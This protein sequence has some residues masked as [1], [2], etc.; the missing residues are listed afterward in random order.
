MTGRE[1]FLAA[2]AG[3]DVDRPPVWIMRQAGRYLP[4]YRQ[5][6]KR[7]S[8]HDLVQTPELAMEVTLQPI[9]RY[10][11][12]A[13]ITFS[14]ILVIPEALGQPYRFADQGGIEMEFVIRSEADFGRLKPEGVIDKLGY[15][16]EAQRGLRKELGDR[17]ALIGFSGTPW[18]LAAYMVSGR[19]MKEAGALA[20]L[21]ATHPDL[22]FSFMECLTEAVTDYLLMQIEAGVDAVQLFDSASPFCPVEEYE[23]WS[24]VFVRRIIGALP[25]GV[26]V[27]L[28]GRESELRL[29]VLEKSGAT[30]L[31]IDED[32]S[33]KACRDRLGRRHAIQGNFDPAWMELEP[34]QMVEHV[35]PVLEEMGGEPGWIANLGHGIRP[36]AKTETVAAFVEQIQSWKS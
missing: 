29:D 18:T 23:A 21:A 8:F 6:K 30:V 35:A 2:C 36:S 27:I 3:R 26:P 22:F 24:I 25:D 1:R 20:D 16:A 19:G 4:E 31:S 9:Q 5:L 33:L 13:A 12:D 17:R 15:V 11:F 28:Y 32:A 7:Y 34:G 10:G 14:D